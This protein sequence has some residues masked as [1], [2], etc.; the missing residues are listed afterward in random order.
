MP[1]CPKCGLDIKRRKA[2]ACPVCST[3]LQASVEGW[4]DVSAASSSVLLLSHFEELVSRQQSAISKTQVVWKIPRRG[5]TYRTELVLAKQLVHEAGDLDMAFVA[6][7][8]LFTRKQFAWKTYT[9][10]MQL[11]R[12]YSVALAI[13]TAELDAEEAEARRRY[14]TLASLRSRENLFDS[15]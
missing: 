10:L 1:P 15:Q 3:D 13:A 11:R 2:G 4:V 5:L 9:S 12:D 6:L 7:D 14:D 8:L